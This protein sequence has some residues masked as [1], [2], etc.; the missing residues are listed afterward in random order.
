MNKLKRVK[1]RN[2]VPSGG[3]QFVPGKAV[4]FILGEIFKRRT[5]G[6]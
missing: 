5:H 6:M 1:V 4:Y 2:A 3:V